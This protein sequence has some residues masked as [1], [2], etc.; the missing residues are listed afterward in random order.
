SG[1]AR[2]L[3]HVV[4]L[5]AVALLVYVGLLGLTWLGFR[6]VPTGFIPPQDAG[7]LIAALQM[8][9]AATIDRTEQ[10][11]SRLAEIARGVPGVKATFAISGFSLLTGVNQTNAATMFVPLTD[12]E[13]RTRHAG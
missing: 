6:S 13:E 3:R 9:D 7:Y 4:R 2:T 10:V 5:S 11:T 12:F 8:P 1:Y